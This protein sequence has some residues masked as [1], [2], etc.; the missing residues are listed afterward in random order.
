MIQIVSRLGLKV[1]LCVLYIV[2][3]VTISPSG[4][5]APEGSS[6]NWF[7]QDDSDVPLLGDEENVSVSNLQEQQRQLLAGN[8]YF[9]QNLRPG[10]LF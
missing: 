5:A 8:V 7:D 10:K 3:L 9:V 2:L 4:I 6:G 1:P